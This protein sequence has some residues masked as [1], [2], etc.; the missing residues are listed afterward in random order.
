[1]TPEQIAE[2]AV[3]G[4]TRRLWVGSPP[5]LAMESARRAV[6]LAVEE[7][8]NKVEVSDWTDDPELYDIDLMISDR[9]AAAIR[10][11]GRE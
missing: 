11:W 2:K 10:D 1:M 4:A 3:N 8:V 6:A 7:I 5:E 9:I